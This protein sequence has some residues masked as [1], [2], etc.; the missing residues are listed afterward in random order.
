MLGTDS[1]SPPS[2]RYLNTDWEMVALADA[3][4]SRD[5]SRPSSQSQIGWAATRGRLHPANLAKMPHLLVAGSTG[6]GNQLRQPM[7]VSLLTRPP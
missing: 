6:F 7:L 1:A 4:M 5:P 2:D 3:S